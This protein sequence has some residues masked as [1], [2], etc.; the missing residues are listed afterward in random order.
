MDDGRR[1]YSTLEVA[2]LP[3]DGKE[4]VPGRNILPEAV[5]DRCNLPE[6][7]LDRNNLPQAVI[8]ARRQRQEQQVYA[9]GLYPLNPSSD[10]SYPPRSE[11]PGRRIGG[12]AARTFWVVAV[13]ALIIISAVGGGAVGESLAHRSANASPPPST[14][15]PA[16]SSSSSSSSPGTPNE[17]SVLNANSRITAVN[18]SDPNSFSHY[19]VFS[20]DRYNSVMVSLWDS[21]NQTWTAVNISKALDRAG[22]PINVK[23]GSALASASTGSPN[24]PFQM[25][26]YYL[27]A[28][29]H[30]RRDLLHRHDGS[31]VACRRLGRRNV[32]RRQR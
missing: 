12:V 32:D 29:K 8:Q 7:V 10:Q 31:K 17:A 15:P 20:Q 1:P 24:W 26:L 5:L 22:D 11:K 25:N 18:W 13:V 23:P 6:A 30:D 19:A 16:S 2:G 3:D 27:N 21:Q 9:D 14:P 28:F 4:A